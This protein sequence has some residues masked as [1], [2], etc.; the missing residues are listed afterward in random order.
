MPAAATKMSRP[1]RPGPRGWP[2]ASGE[3]GGPQSRVQ[4]TGERGAEVQDAGRARGP[5]REGSVCGKEQGPWG[6][7]V[8]GGG[9]GRLPGPPCGLQR[10]REAGAGLPG[11]EERQ[12]LRG[13]VGSQAVCGKPRYP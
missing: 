4:W 3:V 7:G 2:A 5:R 10:V 13:R 9:R 1:G 11:W 12:P 8:G 6:H